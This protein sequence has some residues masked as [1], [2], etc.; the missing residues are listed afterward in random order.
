MMAAA[1]ECGAS[2]TAKKATM[3]TLDAATTTTKNIIRKTH[4]TYICIIDT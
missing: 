4:T 1:H 2:K 3:L